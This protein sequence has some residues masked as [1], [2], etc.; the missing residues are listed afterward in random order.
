MLAESGLR[1]VF[2]KHPRPKNLHRFESYT[3]RH[4]YT[5]KYPNIRRTRKFCRKKAKVSKIV[6][7][8]KTVR[9]DFHQG[10]LLATNILK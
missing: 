4:F 9:L 8:N 10:Y 2:A 1:Q 7:K 3:F 6:V 5:V